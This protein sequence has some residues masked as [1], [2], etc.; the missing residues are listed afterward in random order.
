MLYLHM[1]PTE[2]VGLGASARTVGGK[3]MSILAEMMSRRMAC[4]FRAI[5]CDREPVRKMGG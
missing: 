1:S 5:N 3:S 4:F 2:R